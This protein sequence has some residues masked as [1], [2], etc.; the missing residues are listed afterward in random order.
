[1][2]PGTLSNLVS[3]GCDLNYC[4]KSN[5]WGANRHEI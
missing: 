2:G 5:R 3:S 4:K 1:M